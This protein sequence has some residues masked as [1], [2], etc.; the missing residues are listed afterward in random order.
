ME[1]PNVT[2]DGDA[3]LTPIF[4]VMVALTG[5]ATGLFGDFLMW[6]LFGVQ[7]IAFAYHSG[8][9]Q[10]AVEHASKLP[11]VLSLLIAG[12]FGGIAWYLLRR[13]M[14]YE[15][16]EIDDSVWSGDRSLSVRRSFLTSVISEV[17]IGMGAD[18]T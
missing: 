16:T 17:V 18:G 14:K 12:V 1:Q 5:V 2:G 10:T 6:I 15:K 7:H 4:W 8:E 3:A 9:L 13:Y 11:R